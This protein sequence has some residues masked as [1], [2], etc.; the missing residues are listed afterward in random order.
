MSSRSADAN[1]SGIALEL[2]RV[3]LNYFWSICLFLVW[4]GDFTLQTR[5]CVSG[6]RRVYVNS[7]VAIV[8]DGC[9]LCVTSN[10]TIPDI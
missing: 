3:L 1:A 2:M 9:V 8:K 6:T 5:P 10:A 4:G 7:W